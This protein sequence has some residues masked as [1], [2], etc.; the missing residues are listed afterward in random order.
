MHAQKQRLVLAALALTAFLL[1]L[2][3]AWS[4]AP[5]ADT[6]TLLDAMQIEAGDWAADVGSA[7]G[8]YTLPMAKAVGGSGRVVAVD[9]DEDALKRL[10]EKVIDRDIENVTTVLSVHDNP[11]LPRRAFDALLVRNAYHEFTAHAS[12]L[13]HLYAALKPGG[14][15]VLAEYIGDDL[16]EEN[17]E[18]QVENHEIA[19]RYARRELQ[20]A[21]FEIVEE[22]DALK[23]GV[24]L[25]LRY[26]RRELNREGGEFFSEVDALAEGSRG[27]RM[28]MIVAVRSGEPQ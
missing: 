15:L 19:M 20:R 10:N 11:M 5:P 13:Q 1:V 28:W 3:S 2:P 22:V 12:M 4:Q 27:Y 21:G 16:I 6:D 26:A 18:T 9:I 23:N 25:A 17:R 24:N 14:R 8:P 7:D